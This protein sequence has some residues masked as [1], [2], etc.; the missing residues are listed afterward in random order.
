MQNFDGQ[1]NILLLVNKGL[2]MGV[3]T[4]C[5]SVLLQQGKMSFVFN[6][7]S[8]FGSTVGKSCQCIEEHFSSILKHLL[9]IVNIF[10]MD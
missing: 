8:A 9:N 3:L 6:V 7:C 10:T 2:L 1:L 4:V 5:V